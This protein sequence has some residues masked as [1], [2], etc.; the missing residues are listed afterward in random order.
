MKIVK[1]KYRI[2]N[3]GNKFILQIR[4]M[5]FF[6][7]TV[8][9]DYLSH[10]DPVLF[11]SKM[12]V[13]NFAKHMLKIG[14][15]EIDSLK[16]RMLICSFFTEIEEPSTLHTITDIK[17]F[18]IADKHFSINI[19]THRPGLIIGRSGKTFDLLKAYLQSRLKCRVDVDLTECKL[20]QNL[21]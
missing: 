1:P 9:D 18:K 12:D 5:W 2:L 3:S 20:F 19:E 7:N 16:F 15:V 13:E 14:V 4:W 10:S 6:Y 8:S 21:F 11:N 17:A